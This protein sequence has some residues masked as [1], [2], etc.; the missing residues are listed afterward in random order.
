M[1]ET[2]DKTQED[3]EL[4]ASQAQLG[5]ALS[6]ARMGEDQDL[7]AR[8]RDG[9]ERFV[10]IFYGLLK[11]TEIHDLQNNAFEK[12]IEEFIETGNSL[13]DLLGGIHLVTVEDQVFV[14]DI[15]IRFGRA[16]TASTLSQEFFTSPRRWGFFFMPCQAKN[17]C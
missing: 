1:S 2:I 5:N 13:M 4:E 7:A 12:P 8:V 17:R 16:Q 10:R 15:R 9:G 3:I 14:N 11:M 6:R